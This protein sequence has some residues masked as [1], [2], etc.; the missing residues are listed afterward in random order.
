MPFDEISVNQ[1]QP[2]V[3]ANTNLAAVFPGA[4]FGRRGAPYTTGLTFAYYGGILRVDGTDVAIANGTV[5][6]TGST[7]NYVEATRAGVVSANTSGFTAGRIPICTVV[8][9]SSTQGTPT[10]YRAPAP[11]PYIGSLLAKTWPSD[12]NYTLTAAEA[13]ADIISLSGGSLSTTR[14]L[15]VPLNGKWTVVNGTS[16]GQ[17]IQV[18]G[19]SGTGITIATGKTAIV[20]GDGTNILRATADV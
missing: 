3:P 19:A 13:R 20:Y 18:I 17:S 10:E 1:N 15:V 12:A 16:G 14:N 8:T 5:T 6:L 7:T 9:T 2:S 4:L 11:P